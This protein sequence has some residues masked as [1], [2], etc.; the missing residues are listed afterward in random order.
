MSL[1]FR[2]ILVYLY[3]LILWNKIFHIRIIWFIFRR[4]LTCRSLFTEWNS[5]RIIFNIIKISKV[6]LIIS[7][8]MISMRINH[9][10]L[11]RIILL[12]C[13]IN[14]FYRTI[15]CV[16]SLSLAINIL[17]WVTRGQ[18]SPINWISYLN[19]IKWRIR[20]LL[21]LY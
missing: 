16:C 12:T 11:K 1:I 13:T 10:K 9:S 7:T 14:F 15:I 6:F 21:C 3:Q 19:I 17:N 8:V 20:W 2:I 18:A 4:T 5:L